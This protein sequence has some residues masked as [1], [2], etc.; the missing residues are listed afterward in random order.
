MNIQEH[1]ILLKNLRD[2]IRKALKY[3]GAEISTSNKF[4]EYPDI[5]RKMTIKRN[6]DNVVS[7]IDTVSILGKIK[8]SAGI[9][10]DNN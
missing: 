7:S 2:E 4:T 8:D 10:E 1:L 6:L 3:K 9:R 5:I